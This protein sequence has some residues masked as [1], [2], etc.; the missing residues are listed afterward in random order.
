MR[1]YLKILN[2]IKSDK[3]DEY[4]LNSAGSNP[5]MSKEEAILE[6]KC[7]KALRKSDVKVINRLREIV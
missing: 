6:T 1:D 7:L 2:L 3:S 4:I 5:G